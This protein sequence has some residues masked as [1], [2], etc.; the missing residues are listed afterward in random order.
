MTDQTLSYPIVNS[1]TKE[2]INRFKI[3]LTV[4]SNA[5]IVHDNASEALPRSIRRRRDIGLD[6]LP[7]DA[8]NEAINL[9]TRHG[10]F[11]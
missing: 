5:K 4:N 2:L 8:Q 11:F 10:Q 7:R 1:A 9:A 6:A 3:F